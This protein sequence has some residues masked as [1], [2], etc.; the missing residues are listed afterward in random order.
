MQ[1]I[2]KEKL[3]KILEK[4]KS[5]YKI[6]RLIAETYNDERYE[7]SIL[8]LLIPRKFL[9]FLNKEDKKIFLTPCFSLILISFRL[10]ADPIN[11]K[12]FL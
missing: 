9:F 10:C 3:E 11:L 1:L 12:F 6:K 7:N 5:D 8:N 2:L 4:M